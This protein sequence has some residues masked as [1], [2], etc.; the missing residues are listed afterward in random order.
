MRVA[1]LVL[2][3]GAVLTEAFVAPSLAPRATLRSSA[4]T[5]KSGS[6]ALR[7]AELSDKNALTLAGINAVAVPV[8]VSEGGGLGFKFP[9]K[10]SAVDVVAAS[11]LIAV[12]LGNERCW[13]DQLCSRF[14]ARLERRLP[15]N[16]CPDRFIPIAVVERVHLEEHRLWAPRW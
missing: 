4:S 14:P 11:A 16:H 13:L 7:A 2:L 1:A 3:V 12:S 10:S 9:G 8:M 15:I 5:R 6:L